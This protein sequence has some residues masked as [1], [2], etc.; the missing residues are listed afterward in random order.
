MNALNQTSLFM[1]GPIW[2]LGL[3][4]VIVMLVLAVRRNHRLTFALTL[5]GLACT[6]A[7]NILIRSGAPLRITSLLLIDRFAL[8]YNG[9]II[10]TTFAVALLAFSYLARH[11]ERP[12]EFYLLLMMAAL[13]CLALNSATHFAS[14]FIGLEILSVSLYAM[15]AYLRERE[16]SVEA[17]LKYLVLAG[18]SSAFL[19]FGMALIYAEVGTM[20]FAELARAVR[21]GQER[22]VLAGVG[23]M[24]IGIG[25][26]LAVVPFHM[27]TPDVYEGA[28]APVTAFVATA[29]KG[30]VFALVLRFFGLFDVHRYPSLI[31]LFGLISVASMFGGNLLALMQDNVKRILAYSSISNLGYMLVAFLAGRDLAVQAVTIYLVAYILTILTAFG[32]I[33]V[34]SS[35]GR[36]RDHLEEY[37]GLFWRRPVV[38][39]IFAAALL[40]LAGIPITAGFVGKFYVLMAGVN[41]AMWS[42]VILLILSSVIG[43][44]Y[45]LRVIVVMVD[46]AGE[47]R[48]A[49]HAPAAVA[50]S[51][52]GG[53]ALAALLA[54]V[55]LWGVYP[56][57]LIN[58][59][60]YATEGLPF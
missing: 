49:H 7:I 60:R 9:L 28:P 11:D 36:D 38:S 16:R 33:T 25:F 27:W 17:G 10:L 54:L 47:P 51:V 15:I 20:Q 59:I 48:E 1:L 53:V 14:F 42:L 3:W 35:A 43:L 29:S 13:G 58:W 56:G 23:M 34:I 26:K 18:A 24:V 45:Y 19:L 31:F 2:M 41:Q 8:F 50:W 12:E 30:A 5:I 57:P 40:S 44:F 46:K 4:V 37:R 6:F 52:S 55:I 21:E 32:V 39:L 22:W